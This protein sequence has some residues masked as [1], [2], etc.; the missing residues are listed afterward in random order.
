MYTIIFLAF[1]L[2]LNVDCSL[3]KKSICNTW[4]VMYREH[5]KNLL[6]LGQKQLLN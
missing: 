3:K 4:F 1:S 5:L 2:N 6:W